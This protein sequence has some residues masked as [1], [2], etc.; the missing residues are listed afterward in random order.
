M[1]CLRQWLC[2]GLLI[3][4]VNSGLAAQERD[5]CQQRAVIVNV[6]DRRGIPVKGLLKDNFKASFRGHPVNI[7][8]N[9]YT[10]GPRRIVILL[11]VSA[12][13]TG[14]VGAKKWAIAR[15]AVQGLV[16]SAP[17]KTNIFLITFAEKIEQQLDATF[18]RQ[19][20]TNWLNAPS[21]S[22]PKTL[23]GHTAL[24]AAIMEAFKRLEP[25][26]PGDAIFVVTD[27]G[28][29]KSMISGKQVRRQLQTSGVRLFTFLLKSWFP[30][31]EEDSGATEL[32]KMVRSS[33]GFEIGLSSLSD[34]TVSTTVSSRW[35]YD[36]RAISL[37][38]AAMQILNTQISNF[39]V[40]TVALPESPR[41]PARWRLEAVDLQGRK[42][43]G[44]RLTYPHELD[45]CI[46]ELDQH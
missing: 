13:M 43:K 26:Q 8:S 21:T 15:S 45:T 3:A 35:H 19:A 38:G 1:S 39:Y 37:V 42:M 11:D 25:T 4:C 30:S 9:S 34:I 31:S 18:D 29:N 33:G 27:G 36:E 16:A 32:E 22:D 17:S 20:I 6:L 41:K 23:K 24:F 28:E 46:S 5:N 44:L 14:D 2:S 40:V 12:S 10:S 7:L